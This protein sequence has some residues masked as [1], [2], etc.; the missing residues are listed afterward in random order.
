MIRRLLLYVLTFLVALAVSYF[1][2]LTIVNNLRIELRY[3]L[4]NVYLFHAL[5]SLF[6]IVFFDIFSGNDKVKEQLGFIYLG[7]IVFKV[8]VFCLIFYKPLFTIG[9]L[10]KPES[11]SLLIP[12]FVFLF[13]EVFFVSK[14]LNR[15][16]ETKKD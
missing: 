11:F 2:H 16:I 1:V 8:I 5:C 6:L 3:E 4:L 13:L 10:T 15:T 9:N 12:I 14:M 7:T